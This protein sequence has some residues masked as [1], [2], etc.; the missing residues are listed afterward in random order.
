MNES[1]T[2]PSLL[3]R[4]LA[5]VVLALAAYVLLKVVIGVIAAVAWI[6]AIVVAIVAVFWALRT[7]L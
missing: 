3:A 6:A 4:I 5:V 7:L 2:G 1:D